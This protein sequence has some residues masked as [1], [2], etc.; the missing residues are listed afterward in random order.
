MASTAQQQQQAIQQLVA[1]RVAQIEKL[2]D[3]ASDPS[4][5]FSAYLENLIAAVGGDAGIIWLANDQERRIDLTAEQGLNGIGLSDSP[6]GLTHN[7]KVVSEVLSTAQAVVRQASQQNNPLWV[8]A[9]TLLLAPLHQGNRCVGVVEIFLK[10]EIP[11]ESRGGLLQFLE[12][13]AAL[14]SKF[15][16]QQEQPSDTE[17]SSEFLDNFSRLLYDLQRGERLQPTATVA[18]SDGRLLLGV[19]RVSVIVK[20]GRKVETLAVSGQERVHRRANLVRSME[21]LAGQVIRTGEPILFT[22]Q[23]R[24]WPA[25]LKTELAAYLD[26]SRARLVAFVPLKEPVELLPQKSNDLDISTET[27]SNFGCLVVEHLSSADF[28]DSLQHRIDLLTGHIAAALHAAHRQDRIFLLPLW[29]MLGGARHSLRGRVL[30]QNRVCGRV[31]DWTH[32]LVDCCS[33]RLPRHQRR[34][35]NARESTKYLCPVGWGSCRGE[36]PRRFLR[37]ER[38]CSPSAP[39]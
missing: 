3:S 5:F 21:S 9:K 29:R 18:A 15:L 16:G 1:V 13:L 12:Y 27:Q 36:S 19:D 10:R 31:V 17:L 26:E 14:G 28:S 22:G 39:K 38:G 24:E 2:I 7:Q 11:P 34:P 25:A 20:R 6:A 33:L 32:R 4:S 8:V 23:N 37:E 35:V 30:G